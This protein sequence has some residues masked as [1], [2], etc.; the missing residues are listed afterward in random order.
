MKNE[1]ESIIYEMYLSVALMFA[2]KGNFKKAD[3]VLKTMKKALKRLRD[4]K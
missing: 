4:E 1:I 3:E 2:E